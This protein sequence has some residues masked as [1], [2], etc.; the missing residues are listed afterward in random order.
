MTRLAAGYVIE[1]TRLTALDGSAVAVPGVGLVHLQ[2]RRFAR[3]PIC[4]LHLHSF[5][6]R[7]GDVAAAGNTEVVVFHSTAERLGGY[8]AD[9]PFTVVAD[10]DRELY[11]RFGV[12]TGVRSMLDP[13][14]WWGAVRGGHQWITHHSDPD[15]AGVGVSDGTTHL[16]L[17]ADFLIGPDGTLVAAHYGA[18]ADDQW[19]VDE[20]L[21]KIN[22]A[23]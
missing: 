17:P 8:Q 11:R 10:P 7:H 19:S 1:P 22:R 2:F 4:S 6:A 3:C 14:A 12:E 18:H 5:A 16:G 23:R 21:L 20:L 15:W 13:R 9:L